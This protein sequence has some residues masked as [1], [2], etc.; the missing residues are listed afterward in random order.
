MRIDKI[1][2]IVGAM[3]QS[4]PDISR[5]NSFVIA[6]DAGYKALQLVDIKPDLVVGDFDSLGHVPEGENIVRHP[7]MKDDTDMMLAVKLGLE[8]GF[9]RFHIYGGMGGRTDHTIANIQTLAYIA[10]RGAS[11]FLFGDGEVMTVIKNSSI[12]FC[13]G[14]G[15]TVSAFAIG[16]NVKGVYESGLLYSLENAEL[17]PDFPLG[18]SN[19]FTGNPAEIR[20]E[21]GTLLVTW[22]DKAFPVDVQPIE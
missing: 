13:E 21:N 16:G 5:E 20:V 9:K 8:R 1:C 7:V 18:V 22:T 14:S 3:A 2:Y 17:A 12:R 11:A 15:G 10:N 19:E 4:L 6:A